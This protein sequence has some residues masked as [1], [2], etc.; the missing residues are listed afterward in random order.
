[1]PACGGVLGEHLAGFG[2]A[3]L[4]GPGG[5][6]LDKHEK[7][8]SVFKFHVMPF[9]N[10]FLGCGGWQAVSKHCGGFISDW[11][12]R[13]GQVGQEK[14]EAVTGVRMES[15]SFSTVVC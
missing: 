9:I 1:M 5:G 8:L 12:P 15:L 13:D 7:V 11:E 3:L 10:M 2:W 14:E 4:L 6:H